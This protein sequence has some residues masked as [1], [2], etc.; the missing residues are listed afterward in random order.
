[1][2]ILNSKETIE[3]PEVMKILNL[4]L[5]FSEG[6]NILNSKEILKIPDTI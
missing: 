3:I 5:K 4:I 1:M 2:K 6:M